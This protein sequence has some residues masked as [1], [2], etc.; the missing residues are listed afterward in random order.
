M[1]QTGQHTHRITIGQWRLAPGSDLTYRAAIA[2]PYA[3][4][5]GEI[6]LTTLDQASQP[7]I[8]LLATAR[9]VAVDQLFDNMINWDAP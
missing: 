9:S 4:G 2:V 6:V 1:T 5:G 8:T 7:D 3:D